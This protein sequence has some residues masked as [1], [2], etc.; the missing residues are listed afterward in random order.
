LQGFLDVDTAM[1]EE[2]SLKDEMAGT[3]AV[4][5]LI[6]DGVLYCVSSS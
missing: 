5:V 2:E 4:A 1:L 3:T 6:K